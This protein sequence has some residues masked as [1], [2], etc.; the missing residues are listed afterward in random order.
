MTTT[1][2]LDLTLLLSTKKIWKLTTTLA[3]KQKLPQ[4][5]LLE[6]TTIEVLPKLPHVTKKT[7]AMVPIKKNLPKKTTLIMQNLCSLADTRGLEPWHQIEAIPGKHLK[8][9]EKFVGAFYAKYKG[10]AGSGNT[11]Y[12]SV[13]YAC[14]YFDTQDD[15]NSAIGTPLSVPDS[16]PVK[17][18]PHDVIIKKPTPDELQRT[19]SFT[20]QVLDIPLP[21]KGEKLRPTFSK[22][23]EIEKLNM[24][25]KSLYQHAYI[26]YK[27]NTNMLVFKNLWA[28]LIENHSVRILPLTLSTEDR[29][30][31]RKYV[32][33]L[34]AY[35]LILRHVTSLT[36][37]M[38]FMLRPVLFQELLITTA[39]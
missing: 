1:K 33:N 6:T 15:L 3:T 38:P 29:E 19:K 7:R 27:N 21:W 24:V 35:H 4:P 34:R 22:Y 20:I 10:Y 26:T 28:T 18:E 17:F 14:V 5:V 32:L 9:K 11:S 2:R 25:T 13:R 16:D 12:K 30:L 37:P 39:L 36:S 8:Q 31:R 23:G